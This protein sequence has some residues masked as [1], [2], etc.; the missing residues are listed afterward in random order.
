MIE[1]YLSMIERC[2]RG[3]DSAYSATV[4]SAVRYMTLSGSPGTRIDRALLMVCST[5][6]TNHRQ[7]TPLSNDDDDDGL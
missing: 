4:Q 3:H 1:W 2:Q 6:H 5:P 7:A